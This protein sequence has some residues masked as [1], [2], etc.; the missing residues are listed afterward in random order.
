MAKLTKEQALKK[1]NE[2]KQYI[3]ECDKRPVIKFGQRWM[4]IN[5]T[6]YILA[7]VDDRL[8]ALISLVTGNRYN[9]PVRVK[10]VDDIND[11]EWD[12]ITAGGAPCFT[13]IN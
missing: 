4:Y 3:E 12:E 1:I 9:D 2:L 10:N 11:N 5:A 13:L 6:E 7:Q 8:I